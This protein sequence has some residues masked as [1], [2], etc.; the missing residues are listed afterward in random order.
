MYFAQII[1]LYILLNKTTVEKA[2]SLI[3]MKQNLTGSKAVD[4]KQRMKMENRAV[5]SL[6]TCIQAIIRWVPFGAQH[7]GLTQ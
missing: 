4:L 1:R 7:Q 5:V 2:D 3:L 6:Q